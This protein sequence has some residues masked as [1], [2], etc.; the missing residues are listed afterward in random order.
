M[1]LQIDGVDICELSFE[2]AQQIINIAKQS[3]SSYLDGLELSLN[4][5]NTFDMPTENEHKVFRHIDS[6]VI[7]EL[8]MVFIASEY[9]GVRWRS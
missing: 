1:K 6:E 7:A 9:L 2:S 4:R 8:R 5:P 3:D